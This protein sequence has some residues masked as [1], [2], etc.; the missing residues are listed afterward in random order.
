MILLSDFSDGSDV[1]IIES[2]TIKSSKLLSEMYVR[3]LYIPAYLS[4]CEEQS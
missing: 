4:D 1:Q 2:V 3:R